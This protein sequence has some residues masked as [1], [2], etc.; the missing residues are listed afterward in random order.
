MLLNLTRDPNPEVR[1]QSSKTLA[2]V[3]RMPTDVSPLV[4][5]TLISALESDGIQTPL[6]T[7]HGFQKL[8]GLNALSSYDESVLSV[9]QSMSVT[10]KARIIRKAAQLVFARAG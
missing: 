3:G 4:T 6:L 5:A 7:I 8:A 9:L 2:I 10:H 1:A